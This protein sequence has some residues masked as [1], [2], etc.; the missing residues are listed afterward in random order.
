MTPEARVWFREKGRTE[1]HEGETQHLDGGRLEFTTSHG[2]PPNT[3]LQVEMPEAGDG[4]PG[5]WAEAEVVAVDAEPTG[6]FVVRA[7]I[8]T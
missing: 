2:V 5:I 1:I 3:V 7:T 8:R 6:G 4:L